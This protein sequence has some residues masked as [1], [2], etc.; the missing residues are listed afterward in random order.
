METVS[1]ALLARAGKE[2]VLTRQATDAAL[3]IAGLQPSQAEWRSFGIAA[4]RFAGVMSVASGMIFLVAFNWD[5]LGVWARF[6]AVEIPLLLAVAVAWIKGVGRLSGKLSLMLAVMLTGALL[7]LFGQ[8]YQTGANVYELFFGWAALSFAWVVA[9]RYAPCWALWLLLINLGIGLYSGMGSRAWLWSRSSSPWTMPFLIDL[10]LYVTIVRLSAWPELG[11]S[12]R[13][14]RRAVIAAGM[15]FG[16]FAIMRRII[17]AGEDDG[18]AAFEILLYIAA[19][20]GLAAYAYVQKE[21]LF[22]F[23]VLA[24]SWVCVTT[25]LLGRALVEDRAGLGALFILGMYLIGASTA[26]VK[27]IS[28]IGRQWNTEQAQ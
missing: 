25:M 21:D 9:C 11:L 23:A 3:K 10:L 8:T 17:G 5:N 16:T 27:G 13:W 28:Y 20:I 26:A 19:S 2:G 24:L 22:N 7:A 18:A 15:G 14:L 6:G 12:E 4:M 1:R